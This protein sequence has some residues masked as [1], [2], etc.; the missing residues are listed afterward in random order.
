MNRWTKI[1]LTLVALAAGAA[2]SMAAGPAG[3]DRIKAL[4]GTWQGKGPDGK[5]VTVSYEVISGGSAVLERLESEGHPTMVTAYHA[6]GDRLLM[7]HYCSAG[8]QPRMSAGSGEGKAIEFSFL[9]ATNLKS[10]SDGH[11]HGLRLTPED[12]THLTQE[13]TWRAEGKDTPHVFRLERA[14]K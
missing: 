2:A 5:P 11:M 6:D 3:L 12:D 14:K 13:W 1:T 9:D 8:N 7:T 4:A 10:P